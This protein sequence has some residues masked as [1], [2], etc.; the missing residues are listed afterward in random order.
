MRW[1]STSRL[2]AL[3]VAVLLAGVP[4]QAS[5]DEPDL[6]V[7]AFYGTWVGSGISE[8]EVSIYFRITARDLNVTIRP[9]GS[10]FTVSW[11]TVLRQKGDPKNPQVT[12]KSST[13]TFVPTGRPNVWRGAENADPLDGGAYAWA[14]I[15]GNALVV[16][17]MVIRDDGG[18]ELQ[19]Y[20]RTL[21]GLGMELEFV[22]VSDG[23]PV[24][25][26]KGRLVKHAN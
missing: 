16:Y 17:S 24:R 25:T 18:Y 26:A 13:V 7:S 3:I 14:R 23:E 9:A 15:E 2:A 5:A 10:G 6:R 1:L 12:R 20:R 4:A 11:T 19:T 8:S 22:R 21:S